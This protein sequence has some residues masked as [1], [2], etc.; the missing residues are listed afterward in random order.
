MPGDRDRDG[1]LRKAP[2]L[3]LVWAVLRNVRFLFGPKH[4]RTGKEVPLS[5]DEVRDL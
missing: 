2:N 4:D 5:P 3:R 1:V